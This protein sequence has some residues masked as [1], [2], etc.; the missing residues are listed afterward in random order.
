MLK[1]TTIL[2]S[3]KFKLSKVKNTKNQSVWYSL[4]TDPWH[5]SIVEIKSQFGKP[6]S[7]ESGYEWKYYNR[8]I[9]TK[10]YNWALLRWS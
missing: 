4:L 5:D 7:I 10:K 1:Y 3:N 2:E 8:K 9:A 6:K